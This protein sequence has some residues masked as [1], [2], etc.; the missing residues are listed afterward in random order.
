MIRKFLHKIKKNILNF[1][2]IKKVDILSQYIKTAPN[3]QNTLNIFKDEW[4]SWSPEKFDVVDDNQI[5][6]KDE[7]ISWAAKVFGNFEDKTILELGPCEAGHTYMI[8]NMG[9]RNILA[10]EANTRAFLK[11][12]IIKE[13]FELNRAKFLCG[14]F[15]QF[16][17]QSNQVFDYTIASGVL[18]HMT[19]PVEL[20]ALIAK[21]TTKAVLVC[22]H[23][24][25]SELIENCDENVKRKFVAK[26]EFEYEG[27]KHTLYKQVYLEALGWKGY[28]GGSQTYSNWLSR[29]EIFDAF[30]YFGFTLIEIGIDD[31][32]HPL[33]PCV[34]FAAFK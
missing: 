20:I 22:V 26:E 24:Y 16:L 19:N 12:L 11:C 25:D 32:K 1:I 10:I 28:R 9:A 34:T 23:Y 18:Y 30:L 29:K 7:R 33:G 4:L 21:S 31:V 14:D 3:C 6:F 13:I 17:M 27:F 2:A 8:H 5:K 15:V